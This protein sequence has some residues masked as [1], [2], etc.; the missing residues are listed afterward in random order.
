MKPY[1]RLAEAAAPDGTVLTLYRHDGAFL[2]RIDGIELMS[3]RRSQSEVQLA[4]LA[5]RGLADR[6]DVRVLVGGLGF[7]FTMRAALE[8]LGADAKV[9]VAEIVPEVIAWNRNPE[10]ALAGAAMNDPRVDIRLGDVL[11]LLREHVGAFD[12]I[13][14]DVDNGAESLTTKGNAKLYA[15]AGIQAAIAALRPGGRVIYWSADADPAFAKALRRNGLT[16]TTEK[17]RAHGKKG[18]EHELIVGEKRP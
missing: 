3:T 9:V 12:A 16:V 11:P 1:E 18:A 17:S 8:R 14:L 15:D 5:C 4:A 7:G 10:F 13:M 6:R 2:L